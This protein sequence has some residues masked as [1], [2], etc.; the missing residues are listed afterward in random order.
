MSRSTCTVFVLTALLGS[1]CSVTSP[2]DA[3][4]EVGPVIA[5]Y[6]LT[7]LDDKTLPCCTIDSAGAQISIVGGALT[8]HGPANYTDTA[9]TPG[10]QMS[11][12]CV[13]GIPNGSRLNTFDYTVTL[14]DSTTYLLIPCD[15]GTYTM[16]VVRQVQS[17]SSSTTDTITM[18]F[19]NFAAGRDMVKLVDSRN[20]FE[21]QVYVA[22]PTLVVANPKHRHRFDPAH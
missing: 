7:A 4:E 9:Y 1:G 22:A 19:G 3:P 15:R 11:R 14:P 5:R 20:P 6:K 13:H 12:A 10:G 8:F 2:T 16:L 21:L 18:S 17:G